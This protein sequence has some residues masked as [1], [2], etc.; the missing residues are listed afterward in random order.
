MVRVG[1]GTNLDARR[2]HTQR[3]APGRCSSNVQGRCVILAIERK[4]GRG[5][6][7][8][9]AAN[10]VITCPDGTEI[11]VVLL[12]ATDGRA[13]LGFIAD[14]SVKVMRADAKKRTAPEE[15]TP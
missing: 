7:L 5:D 4:A 6:P 8:N 9:L 3:S 14:R 15:P 11:T 12:S 13:R 10:T 1:A 2:S